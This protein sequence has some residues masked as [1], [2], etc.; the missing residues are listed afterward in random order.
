MSAIDTEA[1]VAG[2]PSDATTAT[3]WRRGQAL[4]DGPVVAFVVVALLL[5]LVVRFFSR[6]SLWLDEALAVNIS[7]LPLA[8]IPEALRRDGAPPLYYLLLHGWTRLF[9][10]GDVA[11]RA[12]SGLA[13]VASLGLAWMAGRR[14]GGSR[15]G[16]VAAL[17]LAS[18]P[19]AVAHALE[20]R[21]YSLVV[22]LALAGYLAVTTSLRQPDRRAPLVAIAVITGALLLTHYWSIFLLATVAALLAA[23]G[24][25]APARARRGDGEWAG[26]QIA[27]GARRALAAMAAG[28]LL[29]VPWLPSFLY[30]MR[31]TGAPWG[32][33]GSLRS[34]FD[35]VAN[36][37]G[38]YWDP[39]L[40]LGLIF[41]GLIILAL[42]GSSVDGRRLEIDLHSRGPG[43]HLAAV[44]LGTLTLGIVSTRI[45]D[46]AF[47]ARYTTVVFPFVLLLVAL[48][49]RVLTDRRYH[50]VTVGLAVVLGFWA[51]WPT[52]TGARTN[53]PKVASVL[54]ARVQPGD[55][56]AYCPDQ[57]GPSVSRLLP[58]GIDQVTFPRATPP[59]FVNWVDYERVNTAAKPEPFADMVL[60]R[61]GPTGTVWLVWSAGYRTFSNKCIKMLDLLEEARP[62]AT[63]VILL[64]SRGFEKVA[65]ARFPPP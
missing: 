38:G 24:W 30:Q 65:L 15:V 8:D 35:T 64:P 42:F 60:D 49:T 63:R 55:V 33:P 21:M 50:H 22:M 52:S 37:A 56:V 13:A 47:A 53:A 11:V 44:G 40:P 23:R 34:V 10:A 51:I 58:A 43:R 20:A 19:F 12:L 54:R 32:K 3:G 17:L 29:F 57:L 2:D 18:S 7:R 48:G 28:A 61:A 36:F 27:R 41:Y 1:A 16:W 26:D 62:D 45:T 25:R 59:Q 6:S 4:G 5:G 39:A 14:L 9:G 46:S 31:H